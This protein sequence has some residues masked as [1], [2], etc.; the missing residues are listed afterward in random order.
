MYISTDVATNSIAKLI[1][2]TVETR[3]RPKFPFYLGTQVSSK[4]IE[5][6]SSKKWH[7]RKK[8]SF[9]TPGQDE[10]QDIIGPLYL[11]PHF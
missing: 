2:D 6:K 4:P 5:D 7:D 11:L 10:M 9:L 8:N 3:I 1:I